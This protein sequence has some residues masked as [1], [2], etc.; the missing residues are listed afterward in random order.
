MLMRTA[1]TV[2]PS[3]GRFENAHKLRRDF[4]RLACLVEELRNDLTGHLFVVASQIQRQMSLASTEQHPRFDTTA[5]AF[6]R[7]HHRVFC[8]EHVIGVPHPEHI[9][10]HQ[11]RRNDHGVPPVHRHRVDWLEPGDGD[12]GLIAERE[13][14]P[15]LLRRSPRLNT[16][17]HRPLGQ[18][19]ILNR[20][21][22]LA[23][24]SGFL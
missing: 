19:L 6:R 18:R 22:G 21:F 24:D 4:D 12:T 20:H 1:H 14:S 17:Q 2:R 13:V 23:Y 9:D 7:L 16:A 5:L 3:H 8:D 15:D 10:T 11:A